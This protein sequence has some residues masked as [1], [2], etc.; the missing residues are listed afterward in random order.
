MAKLYELST[1]YKNIEYLLE[2]GEDNEELEAVLNSLDADV[3][4]LSHENKTNVV[5][6]ICEMAYSLSI[7]DL[8]KVILMLKEH[9]KILRNAVCGQNKL[10]MIHL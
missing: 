9:L 10:Y 5:K 6:M 1:G 4:E 7:D 2:N 3:E 8:K